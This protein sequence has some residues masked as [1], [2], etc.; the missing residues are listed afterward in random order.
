MFSV[1]ESGLMNAVK[2]VLLLNSSASNLFACKMSVLEAPRSL[3]HPK[4]NYYSLCMIY[5]FKKHKLYIYI[6]CV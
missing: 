5:G 4:I 2:V 1:F 3:C 6:S